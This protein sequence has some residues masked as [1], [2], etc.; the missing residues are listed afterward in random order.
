LLSYGKTPGILGVG[1]TTAPKKAAAG[2]PKPAAKGKGKKATKAEE[3]DDEIVEM[4]EDA[5]VDTEDDG[6][7]KEEDEEDMKVDD[8]GKSPDSLPAPPT[9]SAGKTVASQTLPATAVMTGPPLYIVI[10]G[11]VY[12]YTPYDVHLAQ[13]HGVT[14]AFY[15]EWKKDNMNYDDWLDPVPYSL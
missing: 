5:K 11:E 1:K 14:L 10:N 9:P 13:S 6:A 7:A 4:E 12:T 8:T 15:L 2:G 3:E